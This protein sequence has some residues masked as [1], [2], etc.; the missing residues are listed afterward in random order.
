MTCLGEH[1]D[2]GAFMSAVWVPAQGNRLINEVVVGDLTAEQVWCWLV[3][4][5]LWPFY[6]GGISDVIAG[7][8]LSV[9]ALFRY[10][11]GGQELDGEVTECEPPRR[12]VWRSTTSRHIWVIENL[13]RGGLRVCAELHSHGRSATDAGSV[14]Q[15]LDGLVAAARSG[16]PT[17]HRVITG[18]GTR[19]LA[20]RDGAAPRPHRPALSNRWTARSRDRRWTAPSSRS[21]RPS[22]RPR[23]LRGCR[24]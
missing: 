13:H 22:A 10:T 8:S 3:S 2:G 7:S 19:A 4:P 15:W 6:H 18:P 11:I 16:D 23:R 5:L 21:A 14:Q 1:A 12:L 24:R 9:G 20:R 17:E